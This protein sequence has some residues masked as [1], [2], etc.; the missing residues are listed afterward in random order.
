[1]KGIAQEVSAAYMLLSHRDVFKNGFSWHK[2]LGVLIKVHNSAPCMNF[3]ALTII[4]YFNNKFNVVV[5]INKSCA[6]N[7]K[8]LGYNKVWGY[9][10]ESIAQN[11]TGL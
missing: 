5:I 3:Y 1:M 4:S 11:V 10:P 6:S 2:R 9:K 8:D 7:E